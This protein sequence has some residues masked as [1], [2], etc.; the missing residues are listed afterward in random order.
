MS[1]FA[2]VS[3]NDLAQILYGKDSPNTHRATAVAWNAFNNY[4]KGRGININPENI[5][6]N[7]LG[8]ILLKF[9]HSIVV[10]NLFIFSKVELDTVKEGGRI[11]WLVT[12]R[13]KKGVFCVHVHI[14][15]FP[16]SNNLRENTYGYMLGTVNNSLSG[17][18]Y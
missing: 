11:E 4:L 1:R 14:F 15:Y 13:I 2:E 12:F 5:K 10:V 6:K 18:I 3:D 17:H 16:T 7:E 8:D 9:S